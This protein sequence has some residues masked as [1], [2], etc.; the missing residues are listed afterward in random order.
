MRCS[1]RVGVMHNHFVLLRIVATA[2]L[3]YSLSLFA[4]SMGEISRREDEL[5]GLEAQLAALK[6]ENAGLKYRL[7]SLEKGEGMESL[8]REKLGLVMPGERVFYFT[9]EDAG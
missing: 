1:A 2:L 9:T 7:Q 6:E 3:L 4:S 5:A 8:A